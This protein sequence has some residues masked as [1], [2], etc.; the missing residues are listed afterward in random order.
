MINYEIHRNILDLD[1]LNLESSLSALS[2]LDQERIDAVNVLQVKEK[3]YFHRD[4]ASIYRNFLGFC[5]ESHNVY[6]VLMEHAPEPR[7][8]I[9]TKKGLFYKH[10]GELDKQV[11]FET[12]TE[13]APDETLFAGIIRLTDQNIDFVLSLIRDFPLAFGFISPKGKRTYKPSRKDFLETL[14]HEGLTP[15]NIYWK[16]W[17]KISSLLVK[18]GRKFF[19]LW[20]LN[21]TEHFRVFY[22]KDD[23]QWG[24][25]L[26]SFISQE[27]RTDS[28]LQN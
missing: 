28:I 25:Q 11:L 18:P 27:V 13:V 12:E 6:F 3:A 8:R 7:N 21:D 22:H 2:A 24:N 1:D 5:M 19:Y 4:M 17:L 14:V 23:A 9:R 26:E 16:N 10:K 20:D 15:G